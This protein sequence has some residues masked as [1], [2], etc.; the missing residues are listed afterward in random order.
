MTIVATILAILGL[1]ALPLGG[2]WA[3]NTLFATGLEYNLVNWAAFLFGQ[4]YIQIIIKAGLTQAV[5]S[6]KK[7]K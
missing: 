1:I 3:L 4:L 6:S 2:I 5:T 7:S